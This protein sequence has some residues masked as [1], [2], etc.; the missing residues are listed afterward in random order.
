MRP[1][2]PSQ[3]IYGIDFGTTNTRVAYCSPHGRLAMVPFT[4]SEGR[5][6]RIRTLLAYQDGAA[7]AFGRTARDR[8]SGQLPRRSI[9]WLLDEERAV[10]VGGAV[11]EPA[12]MVADFFRHVRQQ[13][14]DAK[15][16]EDL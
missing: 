13:V 4:D 10:E 12:A 8:N 9:K 2:P 15:F 6:Y 5:E 7:V 14:Q 11:I 1:S 16:P 3:G